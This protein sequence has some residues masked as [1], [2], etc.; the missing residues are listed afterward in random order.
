MGRI[1][2]FELPLNISAFYVK[3]GYGTIVSEGYYAKLNYEVAKKL[4]AAYQGGT[5]LS[6]TKEDLDSLPDDWIRFCAE[7]LGRDLPFENV[8]AQEQSASPAPQPAANVTAQAPPLVAQVAK[9]NRDWGD[10]VSG[11]FS[12][13]KNTP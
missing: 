4:N 9:T 5:D 8:T 10:W 3:F 7:K 2:R 11:V 6:L 13:L 12:A 1:Y